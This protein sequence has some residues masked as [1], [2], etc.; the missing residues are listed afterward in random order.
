MTKKERS[1]IINNW[2]SIVKLVFDIEVEISAKWKPK[3]DRLYKRQK[4]GK[5]RDSELNDFA[6]KYHK[7]IAERIVYKAILSAKYK[8][9]LT[10]E[11]IK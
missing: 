10:N 3:F 6:E 7:A 11:N 4:S 5:L 1:D 8:E 9:I 2:K